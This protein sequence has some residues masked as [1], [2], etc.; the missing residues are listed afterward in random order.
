VVPELSGLQLAADGEDV[1]RMVRTSAPG[2]GELVENAL[3]SLPADDHDDV[4]HAVAL[5]RSRSATRQ[6]KRSAAVALARVLEAHRATIKRELLRKDEGTLF[7]IANNFDLRHRNDA[8]SVDYDDEFLEWIFHWY[9][10]TVRLVGRLAQRQ[11][12]GSPRS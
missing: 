10:A 12:A 4:A 6:D 2:L 1:G 3:A 5:Y 8:Q 7:D 9:L 11:T